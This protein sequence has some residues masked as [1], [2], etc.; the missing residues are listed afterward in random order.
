MSVK[1]DA[2]RNSSPAKATLLKVWTA[3]AC[4]ARAAGSYS[5]FFAGGHSR[6]YTGFARNALGS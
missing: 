1:P 2:S 5:R 3:Q 4:I 6:E